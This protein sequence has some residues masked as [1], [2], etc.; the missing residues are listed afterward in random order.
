MPIKISP[1]LF[2]RLGVP[3]VICLSTYLSIHKWQI[4]LAV[5]FMVWIS[6][7]SY[8]KAGWLYKWLKNDFLV[9]IICFAW[10]WTAFAIALLAEKLPVR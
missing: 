10:Y 3:L 7:F 4:F 1:K 9:R 5:P 6:P 8:V 2:R